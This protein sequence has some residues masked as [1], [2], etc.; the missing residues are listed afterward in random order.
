[1]TTN[2]PNDNQP[3]LHPLPDEAATLL[4]RLHAPPRLVAH[5]RLVHD[6]AVQLVDTLSQAYPAL[7]LQADAIRFGA[8]THDIGKIMHPA[9]LAGPGHQH[10]TASEML[11]LHQGVATHLARFART[12]AAWHQQA[13]IPLEDLLVALA[14]TCWKGKRDTE[15]EQRIVTRITEACGCDYWDVF[16]MID[17]LVEQVA[18]AAE[19]R[20][21]W[22][23]QFSVACAD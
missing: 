7:L 2:P 17:D 8:A 22:Q 19:I 5:L 15:L 3:Q 4:Q 10:E 14:D 13:D 6:V 21:A 1:M 12:H 18:A 20:L 9:E 23:A 11:L 16:L